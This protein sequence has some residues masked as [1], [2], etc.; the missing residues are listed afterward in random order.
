MTNEVSEDPDTAPDTRAHGTKFGEL[1]LN[2]DVLAAIE[3]DLGFDKPT[4]I[5]Q[6]AIPILAKGRDLIGKAETGTGKTLAFCAP[7]LGDLDPSRGAVQGLVLCPTREL[8]QQVDECAAVL[9]KRRGLKT[10]LLVGGVHQSEQ[11]LRLRGGAQVVVATPGRVLDFLRDGR[12]RLGNVSFVVLDE[13]DRML[14][15]GFID[16][17]SE[18]LRATPPER[19]TAMFSA[20]VPPRLENLTKRFMRNPLTVST[21][22]GLATVPEIRQRY[23]ELHSG[24]KE[25]FILDLLDDHPQDTCI[26]FCNTRRDVIE[27]DRILWGLGYDAGS[28]HGEHEQERR[29]K[30]LEAFKAKQIK[31]LVAT[32]VA[33][34]GLD[35]DEVTRVVNFD[36]PD[37]VETYVHRIGR[38]GRAGGAGESITLVS[39]AE[40]EIWDRIRRSTKF[41]VEAV[42]GWAPSRPR[43]KVEENTRR[44]DHATRH[45][46]EAWR[47]AGQHDPEVPDEGKSEPADK[48]R[49][50]SRRTR[51]GRASEPASDVTRRPDRQPESGRRGRPDR[52]GKAKEK[53]KAATKT[54]EVESWT[55]TTADF[56]L[57]PEIRADFAKSRPGAEPP[58]PADATRP[59]PPRGRRGDSRRRNAGSRPAT[60]KK[61]REAEVAL[62]SGPP[63]DAGVGGKRK[64]R[65]RGRRGRPEAGEQAAER[66]ERPAERSERPAERSERPAERS[67]RPGDRSERTA[68]RREGRAENQ[69]PSTTPRESRRRPRRGAGPRRPEGARGAESGSESG[70]A[71]DGSGQARNPYA[72]SAETG[73]G[74]AGAAPRR[75]RRRRGGGRP[76]SSA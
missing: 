24:D 46:S 23:V 71:D 18:I 60:A 76:P 45:L 73:G 54:P 57:D 68:E 13:A 27:L 66:S 49:G 19:Q 59:G 15:M 22:Q 26:I 53:E 4:P 65:R 44:K 69:E 47:N 40:R 67:E 64:R 8:A 42:T 48:R 38:T 75:R 39:G 72:S 1:G 43:K 20:T 34:R 30:V 28:L 25:G 14:D 32:D 6:E 2:P 33:A 37:E 50:D 31:T 62:E 52:A 55:W 51:G 12:L 74:E 61:P 9:G 63:E 29:F 7:L 58:A 70:P 11:I 56:G 16:D 5:Q 21:V 10:A 41:E 36:V 35:I 3:Q 17:V